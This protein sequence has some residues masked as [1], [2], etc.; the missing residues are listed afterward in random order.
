MDKP[1]KQENHKDHDSSP[2]KLPS[3]AAAAAVSGPGG[4]RM[5]RDEWSEGAVSSLLEAYEAKWTLRNRAKLKGHDWE[6]VAKYVSSRAN[7]SKSPKTQTQCKNKIESMK[8]RYRSESATTDVSSWPLFPRLDLLLRGSGGAPVRTDPTSSSV[9]VSSNL[10]L[11]AFDHAPAPLPPPPATI[12]IQ[13][14]SVPVSV[15]VAEPVPVPDSTPVVHGIEQN[16]VDSNGVDRENKEEVVVTKTPENQLSEKMET[17]TEC[18]TPALYS[19]DKEKIKTKNHKTRITDNRKRRRKGEN[20]DVAESIRWLAK[21][22][23]RSEQAK[24]ETMRELEKMRADAEVKRGELDLKRTE[25]IA[26]TQLE[27][28][29]LFATCLGKAVDPALR[30][31]RN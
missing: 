13:S 15:S 30:I 22:M 8:K 12:M 26:H 10:H 19:N 3:A 5:K 18:S 6:D 14:S 7:S 24:L 11:I 9:P 21:V 4:D 29:R 16:S 23:M 1:I 28:A 2:R 27:I 25:I 31:G 17:E 20:W